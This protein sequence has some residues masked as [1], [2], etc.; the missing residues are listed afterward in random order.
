MVEEV[1]AEVSQARHSEFLPHPSVPHSSGQICGTSEAIACPAAKRSCSRRKHFRRFPHAV[2]HA[3]P[4]T[5][6][7]QMVV[8][9]ASQDVADF[10]VALPKR[11]APVITS[12]SEVDVKLDKLA[13]KLDVCIKELSTLR[14]AQR[15][16]E[17]DS[18]HLKAPET[19]NAQLTPRSQVSSVRMVA[20]DVR[21]PISAN[22]PRFNSTD[23]SEVES[24]TQS[25]SMAPITSVEGVKRA[26]ASRT[27]P[28][29]VAANLETAWQ[30]HAKSISGGGAGDMEPIMRLV[31]RSRAEH[32]WEFLD[33]PQSSI[34]A[35][36]TWSLLRVLVLLSVCTPYLQE[37]QPVLTL[38]LD[39]CFDTVFM[40]E[41]L[42][43]LVSTPSKRT[44]LKDPLN[45]ADIVSALG[46]PLRAVT[47]F[48]VLAYPPSTALEIVLV[49][50]LPLVRLLKLL[51]YFE[52]FRL[53]LDACKNSMEAVPFLAYMAAVITLSSATVIYL[54]E[55]RS[56]IPSMPHS[57]WLALV[58]MTTVG[59]GDFFPVTFWGYITVSVLTCASVLFL[60][61][62]VA[63]ASCAG[64][65][66]H[67][68]LV[69]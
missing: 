41:F 26:A 64:K 61:L 5:L 39:I 18:G 19:S 15:P 43:R 49:F 30:A 31:Y 23:E 56:R 4:A 44:Y 9:D 7:G 50:F 36:W 33:D 34:W 2:V 16:R 13:E 35:W 59:Y 21:L 60:A 40:V 6:P 48:A 28:R 17:M 3:M 46:L 38:V 55:P 22:V 65:S 1:V 42:S 57:V 45:W 11:P 47:G 62:P 67:V 25:F 14:L 29:R 58:T 37:R 27:R 53:L 63:L 54:V 32:V 51:R 8:T 24:F 52:S 68:F 20:D 10:H 69:A 66:L 12:L